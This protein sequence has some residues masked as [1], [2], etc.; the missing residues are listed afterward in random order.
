MPHCKRKTHLW[1]FCSPEWWILGPT[2]G[3]LHRE[4]T[5]RLRLK[6]EYDNWK[7]DF[8]LLIGKNPDEKI[9][10]LFIQ[11]VAKVVIIIADAKGDIYFNTNLGYSRNFLITN[12]RW[13]RTAPLA[14]HENVAAIAA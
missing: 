2:N 7:E 5:G 4:Y 11:S 14:M 12:L 9:P 3:K 6:S 8:F 10:R 1:W 13:K